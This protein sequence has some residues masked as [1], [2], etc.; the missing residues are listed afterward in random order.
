M[1]TNVVGGLRRSLGVAGAFALVTSPAGAEPVPG[2]GAN[3]LFGG[4]G[5]DDET[6]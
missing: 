6:R 4:P 1:G 5:D 3:L 2:E